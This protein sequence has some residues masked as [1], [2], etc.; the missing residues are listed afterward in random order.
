MS[1]AAWSD[2]YPHASQF[3]TVNGVRIHYLDWGGAGEALILLHGLGDSPHC[4]D[5]L[6]PA[7]GDRHRVIA[8][9]RRGHGSSEAKAPYDADTLTEDL[10]QLLDHLELMTV[11]LAGWSL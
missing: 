7:F 3:A 5:D 8:Y 10:R 11:H 6:A 2:P 1:G 4:F 9:A